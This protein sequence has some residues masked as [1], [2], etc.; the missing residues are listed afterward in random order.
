MLKPTSIENAKTVYTLPSEKKIDMKRTM[1]GLLAIATIALT[2]CYQTVPDNTTVVVPSTPGPAGAP[3]KTGASG[4][5]GA[6]GSSGAAGASGSPG[7]PGATGSP[8][9]TGDTGDTGKTG[10]MGS[11]TP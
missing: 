6:T 8:G 2:G 4:Q 1:L 7:A 10:K 11:D 3:G 5:T 9:K